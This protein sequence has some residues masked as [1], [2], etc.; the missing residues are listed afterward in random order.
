MARSVPGSPYA[1]RVADHE[2]LHV[3]R[4]LELPLSEISWRATTAGG[5]GGQHANRTLSRV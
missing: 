3:H 4:G 5:P 2:T 1:R